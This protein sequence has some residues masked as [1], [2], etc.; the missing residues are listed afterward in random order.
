[1][2]NLDSASILIRLGEASA[3]VRAASNQ[4]RPDDVLDVLAEQA[5][6]LAG[7][8]H[9]WAASVDGNVIASLRSTS[10]DSAPPSA[11]AP[12][13]FAALL[14]AATAGHPIARAS[15][16]VACA[17]HGSGPNP[18]G[19]VVVKVDAANRGDLDAPTFDLA[20]GQL[21]TIAGLALECARLRQR[22]ESVTKARES[23]LASISH[24]LRNPLN[25]FAM[26]AGLLRDDLE[27][28]DV[29]A[30]R[31]IALVSRM[32]RATSRMQAMIEDLVEASRVDA[33]KIEF[34]IR[35]LPAAQLVRDAVA[36]AAPLASEKG[37]AVTA[38]GVDEDVSVMADRARTLQLIA[39]VLAFEAKATGDGGSIRLGVSRH[40]ESVVFTAR[41]FGPGGM[42][43]SPPEEGRGGLA[44]LLARGLVEAQK[45]A[46]R[47]EGGDGLTVSFTLPAAK[48]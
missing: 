19:V 1:M 29:D 40:G 18:E 28:N 25:T 34:A 11:G 12:P 47:I 21:A 6:L 27:R 37:A 10:D 9:A 14:D 22:V 46:F 26:S 32:D 5:R 13:P 30:T 4:A 48:A 23:L 8:K 45:G 3:R 20:L 17:L 41:A 2:A 39:K 38:A 35:S 36:A 43:V 15:G 31:G 33:R 16:Y 42:Q 24:D 44:L 7:A